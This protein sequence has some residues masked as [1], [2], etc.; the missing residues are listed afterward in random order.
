MNEVEEICEN[1]TIMRTGRVVFHGSIKEL[2]KQAPEQGHRLA[3]DDNGRAL[4]VATA[5][6]DLDVSRNAGTLIVRGTQPSVDAYVKA[7]IQH[8][9]SLRRFELTETPLQTLFFNLTE[10]EPAAAHAEASVR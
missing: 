4:D 6:R 10:A 3:T 2:R 9:L 8:G 1:V 7:L 5:H